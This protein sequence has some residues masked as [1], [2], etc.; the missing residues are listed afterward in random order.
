MGLPL[1]PT[2]DNIFMCQ[3]EQIWLD[4]CPLSFRPIFYQ[5]CVDDTFLLFRHKKHARLF[6]NFLNEQHPNIAF[7]M[8]CES[9]GR[10]SFLDCQVYREKNGFQTSVFRKSTFSGLGSSFFSFC[11]FRFKINSIKTFISRGF[12]VCSNY[13][14]MHCE[15]NFF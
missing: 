2:F 4:S 11:S 7:T 1:G 8:E 6:L 9:D 5:R 14:D 10:L 15:L 3:H 12:N 13:P